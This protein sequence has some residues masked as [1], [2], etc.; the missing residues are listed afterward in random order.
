MGGLERRFRRSVGLLMTT[1]NVYRD[2]VL[3]DNVPSGEYED[4]GLTND[5][6]YVYRV[7]AVTDEGEGP[8]SSPLSLIPTAGGGG[9]GGGGGVS[10]VYGSAINIDSKANLQV[11][12]TD[13]ARLSHR[14]RASTTSALVSC[15]F[16]QR[17][18]PIYSG[19][20][21]GAMSIAV[22]ADSGGEPTGSPLA[23]QSYTPGNPGGGWTKYDKVTWSS[24]A[25]LTSGD[26]YHIVYTNTDGDQDANYISVNEVFVFGSTLVPRQ[27][28]FPDAD[29]AVLYDSGSGWD[30]QERY[31]ADMD[32]TYADGTHDGQAYVQNMIDKY[33]VINGTKM[34]RE[35]FTVSG[36]DR[37]VTEAWVRVRRSSGSSVLTV[38]LETGTGTLI[39]AQTIP[40]TDVPISA[41]GGDNGGSVWVGVTFDD[42]HTLTNGSTYNLR[43]SSASDTTYTAAPIRKGT[44]VGL[45][46]LA[47]L[48]GFGQFTTNGTSWSDLYAFDGPPETY[49]PD[50]QF[51]FVTE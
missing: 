15:R 23:T 18:G 42:T 47:F 43:L 10:T 13:H 51:Y 32:L 44:N 7:S 34:A 50:L 25:S 22:Y 46:S 38:T 12:W 45:L 36:G 9:G 28:L 31:T 17:G 49:N 6:T 11:G 19:G 41:P 8:L 26:L 35:R 33:A 1:F 4:T 14:F 24:P 30:L 29:Y 37:N 3:I 27:P 40:A 21:G 48:D 16:Q 5:T 2:G 20:D 39:E